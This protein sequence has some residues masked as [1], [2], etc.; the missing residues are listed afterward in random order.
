MLEVLLKFCDFG[1]SRW[2]LLSFPQEINLSNFLIK[3]SLS[4][5][6]GSTCNKI[7]KRKQQSLKS[8]ST[9]LWIA[10][11]QL[12]KLASPDNSKAENFKGLLL[13]K[14]TFW[15]AAA[16]LNGMCFYVFIYYGVINSTGG[17]TVWP[18]KLDVEFSASASGCVE[19]VSSVMRGAGCGANPTWLMFLHEK[20]VGTQTITE[21]LVKT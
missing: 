17:W 14:I 1:D 6:D 10:L 3:F 16:L 8:L 5:N 12:N 9:F 11:M 15:R 18:L 2:F 20:A 7:I 13:F 4:C 21:E 19:T